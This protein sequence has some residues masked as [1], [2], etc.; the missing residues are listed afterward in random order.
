MVVGVEFRLERN[1]ARGEP[2]LRL[3]VGIGLVIEAALQ[4]GTLPGQFLR[5][6]G[7]VLIAG[8]T[9]GYRHEIG[10]PARAAQLTAAGTQTANASGLLTGTDLLHLDTHPEDLGQHLDELAE[11]DPFVGDVVEDGLVAIALI[12][13]VADFHVEVQVLGNLAGP[14]HGVV[15]LGLGLFELLE[16]VGLGLA[17]DPLELGIV[18]LD[19][20]LLHL[21]QHQP[22]GKGHLADVVP[23]RSLDG[24]QIARHEPD[25]SRVAVVPFAGI[26]EPHLDQ[27]GVVVRLGN[28][29][30][31]VVDL[32]LRP[33]AA[34]VGRGKLR[35]LRRVCSMIV[36]CMVHVG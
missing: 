22:A 15:L 33:L 11:V 9:G 26:L 4:F 17:V 36:V 25:V 27:V 24:Y 35:L 16:V 18:D 20:V 23:R 12:L 7:N 6:E 21:Q 32:E 31:P 1:L 5:I 28:V 29:G 30:Q 19:V 13:D 3:Y 34:A 10:H 8:G 2:L 14:D